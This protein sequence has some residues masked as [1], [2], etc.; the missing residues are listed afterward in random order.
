[1][2]GID[3]SESQLDSNMPVKKEEEGSEGEDSDMNVD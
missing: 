3:C 1:M 2:M